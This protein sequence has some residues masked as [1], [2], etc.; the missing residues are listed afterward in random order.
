[1]STVIRPTKRRKPFPGTALLLVMWCV[2]G[3]T[4]AVADAGR[5][6]ASKGKPVPKTLASQ[7]PV[8]NDIQVESEFSIDFVGVFY[9]GNVEGGSIRF[10]HGTKWERWTA[11]EHDGIEIG[12]RWASGLTPGLDADA[13]QVRIPAGARNARAVAINTTDGPAAPFAATLTASAQS[14]CSDATAIVTRCEWGADETMM[15]WAPQ[16]Y[17]SQKLTVHH[18]ATANGDADPAATV[19]AI[20]RYQAVDRG[21]GDIGYQYLI[22]EQGRVYE[23]RYSGN[24]AYPA[25]DAAGTNVVTAAHIAGYNSGNTGI[26]LIGTLT[27]VDATAAARGA[28]EQLLRELVSRHG[29]DPHGASLYVNPVN[30]TTKDV[31]NISGHRDWAATECPGGT[32]YAQLPAIR[33]AV[34]GPPQSTTTTTLPPST[35]TTLAPSTTTTTLPPSTSSTVPPSTT[36]LP[37]AS[38]T[39]TPAPRMTA[40][41]SIT[42]TRSTSIKVSATATVT[43]TDSN[44]T[45][46][47]VD[48][49]SVTG[50]WYSNGT[51]LSTKSGTTDSNGVVRLLS[52]SFK[53]PSP[54]EVRFCVTSVVKSGWTYSSEPQACGTVPV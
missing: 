30:G 17:T 45:S 37:P 12:G 24:D 21:F 18:T 6:E 3:S 29:I 41:V 14:A 28:L 11:L 51:L 50:S 35:T 20:Y 54:S 36:T 23:G 10:R 49:A 2:V 1:M 42:G 31:A 48:G 39:T 43:I 9:D 19:R 33:D 40:A 34:A 53:A 4:T 13:Y 46:R 5:G 7:R 26:A 16:Y 25:H 8:V 47:R 44:N 15:T 32:F 22:D 52:G 38:T 27:S